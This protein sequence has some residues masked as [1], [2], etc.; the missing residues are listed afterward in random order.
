MRRLPYSLVWCSV[1]FT[2]CLAVSALGKNLD[3]G[4][5]TPAVGSAARV[6]TFRCDVTPPLG[7]PLFSCDPIRTV[8]QPLLAKGVVIEASGDRYVLCAFDWCELCNGGHLAV[9]KA[10]AEAAG[11]SVDHV[12]VQCVHQHTAPLV[13]TNAQKLLAEVGAAKQHIDPK[14]FDAIQRRLAAA[15]RGAIG[16]LE[17]FDHIGTGQAKVDRVA[18]NRRCRDAKGVIQTRYSSCKD[19]TIRALPEGLIDPYLKTITLA[20]GSKPLVR[21]HYYATHPQTSYGDKRASSD[22]AGDAR[23][24]LERREKVFQIYFNGCGGNITVGKY[25]DGSKKDRRGL[26]ERLLTGMEASVAA[27]KLRPAVSVRWRTHELALAA[28]ADIGYNL[29]ASIECLKDPKSKPAA[30][31]YVGAVRAAF[32][33]RIER[34]LEL[35]SLA[36]GDVFIVNLPGEPFVEYQLFAQ[37]LRPK[38]FVAV[39]GYGDG[40]PGYLCTEKAFAEGGYEPTASNVVPQSEK[41]LKEAI[42]ALVGCGSAVSKSAKR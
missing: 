3:E 37:G 25:N 19:A 35:S 36:I 26:A 22:L 9:R 4:G 16:R 14:V 29:A 41:S 12:A 32:F 34:P 5:G 20:R 31:V 30:R 1:L 24:A 18:S 6:A 13:D 40:A 21:L 27:T 15:V 39:A 28:R 11:T 2:L 7:Q 23:E 38:D 8:E 17:P 10:I 42:A 33:H